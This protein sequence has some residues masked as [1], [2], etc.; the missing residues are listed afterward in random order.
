[1][2]PSTSR[3]STPSGSLSSSASLSPAIEELTAVISIETPVIADEQPVIADE[4]PN[5]QANL[6]GEAFQKANNETQ[7]WIREHKLDL[8]EQA[9]PEDH[10]KEIVHLIESNTLFTEKDTPSKI[11]IG[12]QKI[13]FRE[14]I[15]G[16][17][18]FLTMAGD[19]AI[20]FA[21]P[22]ASAPWAV[23][24]AVLKI[25]VK[26]NE[27]MAALAGTAQWFTRIVRKGQVYELLY[28]T[29]TTD[30][31][32]VLSLHD[33]LL[34]LYIAAIELLVRSNSLFES[35]KAKQTLNA[36]LRPE[37]ATGL[38]ADLFKKEQ[39][40]SLEIQSCEASRSAKAGKRAD[41]KTEDLFIT[42]NKLS[43][44][45]IRIDKRVADLVKKF[46]ED[47]LRKLL[48]FVSSEGHGKSH[49]DI[50]DS[51]IEDTGDWLIENEGFLDWQAI[52]SSSTLLWLK[53]TVGTGK[54]YLTWRVVDYVK[55]LHESS[56][57]EGFAF[58]YCNRSGTSLQD[59]LVIL[60]SLVRQL[61]DKASEL[62]YSRLI[63]KCDT[64]KNEGRGLSLKDCK[65]LILHF[66]NLYSKTTI[67]LDAL[68]ESSD[69]STNNNLAVI[70]IEIMDKAKKPIKI[71]MSSRPDREYLEAFEASATITVDASNQE[72]DIE[73]YLENRLYSTLSFKER[74]KETQ[75]LIRGAFDSRDSTM[76][77]WVHLQV[78]R[79]RSYTS[80]DA[81][82]TWASTLPSNLTEAYDQLFDDMRRHDEHDVA[83]AERAIKWV[84]CSIEPLDCE[85]LLEA[86]RYS[87]EGQAWVLPHASVAEYFEFKGMVLAECDLFASKVSLNCL[88]SSKWEN[89]KAESKEWAFQSFEEYVLCAW[90]KH[91]QRYDEWLGL[92]K[93]ANADPELTATL[94][95]FL[96]SP[97]ESSGCYREWIGKMS[98]SRISK[99][100]DCPITD[101]IA[102]FTICRYGF[103][104]T[105]RDWWEENTIN[106]EMALKKC[107]TDEASL[108]LAAKSNCYPICKYLLSL[109][110]MSY[111]SR[112]RLIA[113]RLAIFKGNKN[114][115]SLL[116]AEAEIDINLS[117]GDLPSPVQVAAYFRP[118]MLQ[119]LIDQGWVDVNRE[120]GT[121]Y[122]SALITA[123]YHLV[124]PSV[125]I[126]LK[127]G[128]NVNAAVE[129]GR[130]YGSAL[131]AAASTGSSS[132]NDGSKIIQILLDNG[133]DANQPLKC[134]RY[135]SALEGLV[136]GPD[137]WMINRHNIIQ[138]KESLDLLL[139]AGAD[140]AMVLDRGEYGSAL[141]AAAFHGHKESLVTMI[142]AT[143][144]SQAIQCLRLSRHPKR[145][146][147]GGEEST[148][149]W[150][151]DRAE[152][153]IYLTDQL[154]VDKETLHKIGLWDATPERVSHGPWGTKLLVKF[155]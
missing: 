55:T 152:T 93:G 142:N 48:Q 50:A 100:T 135:G 151:E 108:A 123:A 4:Q 119:W 72:D 117:E 36:I 145:K 99:E 45:L 129:C 41:E 22:Q 18:A 17:V 101:N 61:F 106:K 144:K 28:N 47:Q 24:K 39:K 26:Q 110:G 5:P 23:V 132:D 148:R 32:A 25:P 126:L 122:G 155:E 95:R 116:M 27:Q 37:Q 121:E 104:Y 97:G 74:Q 81:V 1:M 16:V 137:S 42:L 73:K 62:G 133:A 58:F 11:E 91:I 139:K 113:M 66:I 70:L 14:Y 102:L 19:V 10:I 112:E 76:F 111:P 6:W 49:A 3:H 94:K 105:L 87:L 43:S 127:A 150:R 138:L 118:D 64:A 149:R 67:V 52:P 44:P 88:M 84:L 71:F 60:R 107:E 131:V 51:R 69:T 90:F 15:S 114:L 96:G 124:L 59:P 13:V 98:D 46:N 85:V 103:Y 125:E 143:T 78:Q 140:P 80:Y 53:G 12:H 68:D 86:I 35:G 92:T 7:K 31:N 134:G 83:L 82:K 147:I 38:I 115:A 9:K 146:Y 29:K 77:R 34:D 75:E 2:P 128:A 40:L 154:G 141:A 33:T 79:L 20:N 153:A 63:Q 56:Y 54:T 65:E 136:A 109:V 120:S 57:N 21:P 8:A 130:E 89:A 30:E